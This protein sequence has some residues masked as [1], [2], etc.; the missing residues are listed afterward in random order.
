MRSSRSCCALAR[1]V[2]T[3]MSALSF[4]ATPQSRAEA[5]SSDWPGFRGPGGLGVSPEKGLPLT[6]SPSE[7]ILWKTRLPGAGTSSP[8][9]VGDRIFVTYY[10]GF[11]VPGEDGGSP[12]RLE[13]HVLC[14]SPKDGKALWD[15]KVE[16]SLPEKET[17]REGHGYA[18]STPAADSERVYVLFGKSGV[19]ALE[20]GGK[21]LW[22]ADV[23]SGLSG[24]GSAASP[25]LTGDL[26]IVN[27]SVESESLVALERKTGKEVWR[28]GGIVESWNTPIVVRAPGGRTE[29]VVAIA[30]KILAF[31]PKSGERLWTCD[32]D[33]GW[34]MVP[35]LVAHDGVIYCV[36]GRSGGALAVRGGGKGD[37]TSTH[38]IWT[39]KK[40]S[41]VTSPVFHDGHLYWMHENLGIAYCAEA[42][43]GRIA[44]EV[45]V[46]GCGQVYASPV[47][48][49]GRIYQLGR[50]GRTHVIAAG[51]EYER[52][53]V[54]EIGER[55]TF[56]AGLVVAGG[57]F[58]LRSNRFL[59]AIGKR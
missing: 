19:F 44:Y 56:N 58:Y 54:N 11:A 18:S 43:T 3:V 17:I 33:I 29:L 48:V 51:P 5:D 10:T 46:E 27:A 26:L 32:T 36:G 15:T 37:V 45:R 59:Y 6:W 50:D 24:W 12:D 23:G 2:L 49:E 57:R 4:L 52:L 7:T 20:R 22:H 25:V 40:G 30:G 21:Q 31:D 28:A 47:L 13:R 14:L 8:V 55:G 41:N 1:T 42:K 35:G 39:G 38:R 9:I 53:A 16:S 34:Y